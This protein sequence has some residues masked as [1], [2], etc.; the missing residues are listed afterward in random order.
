M[1]STASSTASDAGGAGGN[2]GAKASDELEKLGDRDN[3]ELLWTD[4]FS[5]D[6]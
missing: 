2:A 6:F 5:S 1:A 3:D 4:V